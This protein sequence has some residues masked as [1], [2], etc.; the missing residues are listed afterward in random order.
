MGCGTITKV[1]YVKPTV[2]PLPAKPDYYAVPFNE[3][4]CLDEGGAKNLLKNKALIDDYTKQLEAIIE[5][6]R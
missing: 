2:P 6:L 5:G 1:Q 4:Y 3:N